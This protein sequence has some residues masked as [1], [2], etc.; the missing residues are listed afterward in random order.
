MIALRQA[1]PADLPAL[2]EVFRRASLSND[3]DRAALL[4]HPE[5]VDL[6]DTGVR[7]GRTR[8]AVDD[9]RIVGFATLDGSELDDVF[10]DPD[11]MREG[12]GRRLVLDVFEQART[13]GLDRVEVT[14]N[15][16]ASAFYESVGFAPTGDV[17]TRFGPA[18]RMVH[19][20]S[21][22]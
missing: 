13:Q 11:R 21:A 16:H 15:P 22:R 4:A 20:F 19:R 5:V 12:I 17:E 1:V 2:A 7:E 18:V 6:D 3:G 8:V 14:A 9:S 10:V